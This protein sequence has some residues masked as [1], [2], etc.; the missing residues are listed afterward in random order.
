[1]KMRGI[2]PPRRQENAEKEKR[3]KK[4]ENRDRGN[5]Y[6]II[7]NKNMISSLLF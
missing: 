3:E 2:E 1:M 7:K 5:K 6:R 4:R